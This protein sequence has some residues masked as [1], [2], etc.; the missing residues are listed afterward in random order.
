MKNIFSLFLFYISVSSFCQ[1]FTNDK[2]LIS[3]TWQERTNEVSSIYHDTYTFLPNNKFEFKPTGY[4]GL[5]RIIKITGT[6]KIEENQIL[7]KIQS[8]TEL[9]GGKIQRSMVTTLSDSWE[10][11]GGKLVTKNVN[12]IEQNAN[13]NFCKTNNDKLN[14]IEIDD[15]T[16]FKLPE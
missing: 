9:V 12:I 10:I 6:Y 16:Y 5:N 15:K 14:C 2:C 8:V 11:D 7:F 4:N 1:T 13:F 3:G